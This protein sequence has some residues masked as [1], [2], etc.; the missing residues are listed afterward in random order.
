MPCETYVFANNKG[1]S[2]KST[3]AFQ[4]AANLAKSRPNT[5]VLTI[6]LSLYSDLTTMLCGGT[7]RPT[8]LAASRGAQTALE[9]TSKDERVEGLLRALATGKQGGMSEEDSRVS[10]LFGGWNPFSPTKKPSP[11]VE[12]EMKGEKPIDLRRYAVRPKDL[13]EEVAGGAKYSLPSN[14]W[15]CC[16]CGELPLE[17]SEVPDAVKRLRAALAALPQNWIVIIDTDHLA[18]SPVS[19]LAFCSTEKLILPLSIDDND[20]SR[21][22]ID[23]TGNALFEVLEVLESVEPGWLQSKVHKVVFNSVLHYQNQPSSND[24]ITLPFTPAKACIQQMKNMADQMHSVH[25]MDDK[26]VR[27]F[28]DGH[29]VASKDQFRARYFSGMRKA[30]ELVMNASKLL[31]CPICV[32]P[33]GVIEIDTLSCNIDSKVLTALQSELQLLTEAVFT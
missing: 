32:L 7:S 28:H 25:E 10:G 4:L 9:G 15:V 21:L 14:L 19:E 26:L 30:S 33:A 17:P 22:F 11:H 23:P 6:D 18:K 16:S 2:G 5:Q 1:G 27:F 3:I 29:K 12:N 8:L 24:G 31:G 13:L 20:F